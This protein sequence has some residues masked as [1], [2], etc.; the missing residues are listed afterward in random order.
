LIMVIDFTTQHHNDVPTLPPDVDKVLPERP[1]LD[2]RQT[3]S[4]L[5]FTSSKATKHVRRSV[6][7]LIQDLVVPS[8]TS[9]INLSPKS[10][11]LALADPHEILASCAQSCSAKNLSLSTLL[12][13]SAV[14]G[15]TPIYWAIANYRPPLL[16]ALLR[17]ASP[18]T[19]ATLSDMRKACL[20]ASNK[21]LFQSL[22]LSVGLCA[23]GLRSATD[24]L[25]LGQRPPD[26][27]RI[28]VGPDGAFA[29]TL[30]I[31]MW[32][33]RIRAVG[34]VS[35]EFIASG[36]IFALT[37]F[38]TDRPQP[39]SKSPKSK[40]AVG[41]LHISLSLLDHS[42]PTY[43]DAVVI[44]DRPPPLPSPGPSPR[45]PRKK[46][47]DPLK[48]H[49]H[50]ASFSSGDKGYGFENGV[51]FRDC[52]AEKWDFNYDGQAHAR[53]PSPPSSPISPGHAA[54]SGAHTQK[55]AQT[56][57]PPPAHPH[58]ALIQS[59]SSPSLKQLSSSSSSQTLTSVL[60]TVAVHAPKKQLVKLKNASLGTNGRAPVV[61]RFCAGEAMLACNV[62]NNGD[63]HALPCPTA[64]PV[65]WSEHGTW[66]VSS[67][68]VPLGEQDG[69]GLMF[70]TSPHIA[71]DGSLRARLEAKLVKT[72][73]R[74]K[75][76]IIC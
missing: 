75:E 59:F 4:L 32:Q 74:G 9:S 45:S 70:D 35:V 24:G 48:G 65:T 29:A 17:H 21:V 53:S 33:K 49:I 42:L 41:P 54:S 68:V 1:Q 52:K 50:S 51:G 6:L 16:D 69:G 73:E 64:K 5:P 7:T 36:R 43:V 40:R 58:R 61:L 60:D 3:L 20:V 11:Q 37:F 72:E 26:E 27:V 15:H 8:P 66:Y 38:I 39:N 23:S 10:P 18:L 13:K 47:L 55:H 76:C 44:I 57:L 67:I 63:P 22:R 19:P 71:P 25:L 46:G 2:S 30:D 28:E 56:L 14:T 34:S 31:T 62:R 12:Q